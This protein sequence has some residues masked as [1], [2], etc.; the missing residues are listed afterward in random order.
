MQQYLQIIVIITTLIIGLPLSNLAR[1]SDAT[2]MQTTPA[3]QNALPMVSGE[4]RKVDASSGKITIK[5][6]EIP[7]FEIPAMTMLFKAGDPG[8]LEQ[9]KAGDKVRFAIDK[10]DG[11]LTIVSLELAEAQ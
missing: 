8:M 3:D 1:A 2:D 9:F 5:H 10:V 11:Q 4:I 7:N 6:E